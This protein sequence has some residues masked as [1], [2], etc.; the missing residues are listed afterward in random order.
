MSR[1]RNIVRKALKEWGNYPD[2]FDDSI[3][4]GYEDDEY[5]NWLDTQ[6]YRE[7][8]AISVG[9]N[10]KGQKMFLS[11]DFSIPN[12]PDYSLSAG[13]LEDTYDDPALPGLFKTPED[14]QAFGEKYK[15]LKPDVNYNIIKVYSKPEEGYSYYENAQDVYSFEDFKADK[16]GY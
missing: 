9:E 1:F 14:A 12:D 11:A 3:L 4:D 7:R 6:D 16:Y 13:S 5:E 15:S 10:E 2:G 8:F